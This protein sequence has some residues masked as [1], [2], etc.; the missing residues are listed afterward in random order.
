MDK[1]DGIVKS[2]MAIVDP[3]G[4][5]VDRTP[6]PYIQ[7]N[8]RRSGPTIHCLDVDGV[9]K[10]GGLFFQSMKKWIVHFFVVP[11]Q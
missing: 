8:M 11:N 10:A 7:L 3:H 2:E 9:E 5:K 1:F 4:G 6:F